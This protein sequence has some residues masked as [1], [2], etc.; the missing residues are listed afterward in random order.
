M[1]LLTRIVEPSFGDQVCIT[2]ANMDFPLHKLLNL[3]PTSS[4]LDYESMECGKVK[5]EL[6]ETPFILKRSRSGAT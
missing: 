4:K 6:S 3:A 2:K 1:V 5:P